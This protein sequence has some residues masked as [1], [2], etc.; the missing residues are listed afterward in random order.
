M[1][2][3]SVVFSGRLGNNAFQLAAAITMS[4]ESGR[5]YVRR[6][7]YGNALK[8]FG[9][10]CKER[11]Q[12]TFGENDFISLKK[13]ILL[14][15]KEHIELKGYFQNEAFVLP[16]R[17]IISSLV[18]TKSTFYVPQNSFALHVRRGD[19]LHAWAIKTFHVDFHFDCPEGYYYQAIKHFPEDATC[20]VFSD[21]IQF[22]KQY[23]Q[24]PKFLYCPNNLTP[25]QCIEAMTRCKLGVVCANSSFSLL[26]ASLNEGKIIVPEKW[27]L[28][29]LT[30]NV[31]TERIIKLIM[32][33][34]HL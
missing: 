32:C 11:E 12:I 8:D 14:C 2:T 9:E 17:S 6:T 18:C 26:G 20:V 5:K 19:Y 24:G 25:N 16:V 3:L 27:F 31:M 4:E 13:N 30:N 34:N 15:D 33:K 28:N 10:Y 22:C 29:S 23:F 1:K 7:F 21:D